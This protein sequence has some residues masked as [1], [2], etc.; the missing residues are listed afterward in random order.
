MWDLPGSGI[1]PMSG[2]ILFGLLNNEQNN[3]Q[4]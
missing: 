1:K 2:Q 4:K 3:E